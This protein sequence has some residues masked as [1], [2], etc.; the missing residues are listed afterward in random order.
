M[1]SLIGIAQLKLIAAKMREYGIPEK[2]VEE[3]EN[4]A[5]HDEVMLERLKE[6]DIKRTELAALSLNLA[7]RAY[8]TTEK[9]IH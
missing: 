6:W 2:I 7:K 8:G 4:A 5:K 3:L 9:I 1:I